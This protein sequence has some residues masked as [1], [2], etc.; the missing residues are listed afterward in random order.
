MWGIYSMLNNKSFI[1]PEGLGHFRDK[2]LI[3][4]IESDDRFV[5]VP[6][7]TIAKPYQKYY[8]S[9]EEQGITYFRLPQTQPTGELAANTWYMVS[10]GSP[11]D[12][13][14][15]PSVNAVTSY[16][17][18][19]ENELVHGIGESVASVDFNVSDGKI[20]YTDNN[21]NTSYSSNS[22]STNTAGGDDT[23]SKIFLV[24]MTAQTTSNGTARTYTQD[25]AYVGTDGCLYSGGNYK[26]AT[27]SYVNSAIG[28]AIAASY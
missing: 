9:Y 19:I 7:G 15:A 4:S 17:S 28:A 20:S 18:N 23:S 8:E 1:S 26:V 27:E 12:V 11:S 13:T 25:T 24:G 14:R 22:I 3:E 16:V 2:I 21:G 10:A 5:P 6:G